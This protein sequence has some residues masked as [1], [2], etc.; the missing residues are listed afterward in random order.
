M[1][2]PLVLI[3]GMWCTGAN[4]NRVAGL[5]G[6]RG[7]GC[8]APT[9]PAHEV[10]VAHPEVGNLS[11]RDYLAFL[12]GFVRDQQ[13]AEAP[14]LIGHSM[15][16][17]LAQQLAAKIQ[18]FA[19]VLLTPGA[20]AG[21]WSLYPS[22]LIAFARS[23]LRPGWWRKPHKP[24]RGRASVSLFNGVARERHVPLYDTLVEESGRVVLELGFSWL[25]K[26]RASAVDAAA[27]TCPVFVV[28]CGRD[29]LTPAPMVRKVAAL[30]P[31]A[32]VRHY[33][34]RGHWVLDDADTEQMCTDIANWI[35]ARE[36]RVAERGK[37]SA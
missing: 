25:D 29:R 30:Y 22:N 33:P 3:H 24:S 20:P 31:H 2:R 13:Y 11:L 9:L 23:T 37:P 10:G 5:L 15:G 14:V 19:L 6:D 21:I 32:A 8:N 27:I 16:A 36:I 4:W 18:P 1:A 35:Q 26:T 7:F 17:L 12:E 34:D 28:G